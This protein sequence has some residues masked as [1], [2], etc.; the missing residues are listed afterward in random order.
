MMFVLFGY[1]FVLL[2]FNVICRFIS[3]LKLF[4]SFVNVVV[5]DY[6]SIVNLSIFFCLKWLVRMFVGNCSSVY[7]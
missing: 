6:Y 4:V 7:D 2:M 5:M 3:D 1:V